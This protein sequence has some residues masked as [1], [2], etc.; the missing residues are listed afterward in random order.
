MFLKTKLVFEKISSKKSEVK[1]IF[2]MK[3][4][5]KK[6]RS[7]NAKI[8]EKNSEKI[9]WCRFGSKQTTFEKN[10]QQKFLKNQ[11]HQKKYEIFYAEILDCF[12]T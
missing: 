7:K 3:F 12:W 6:N 4:F 10:Y 1:K 9:F 2:F 11:F 5:S 8:R